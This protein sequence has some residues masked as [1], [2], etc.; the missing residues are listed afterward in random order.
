[1][2]SSVGGKLVNCYSTRDEVLD[3][4]YRT[5]NLGLS[6]PIGVGPIELTHARLENIDCSE[7]VESHM[8]WKQHYG[9]ILDRIYAPS[10]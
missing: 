8:T 3:T 6:D 7:I 2:L 10:V 4:L 1:M 9:Q 5:A